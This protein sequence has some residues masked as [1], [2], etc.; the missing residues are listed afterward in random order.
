MKKRN[1][2]MLAGVAAFALG[3]M[4]SGAWAA[5]D[6][7]KG[8]VRIGMSSFFDDI[9]DPHGH[10][11]GTTMPFLWS[12][13]DG[14]VGV[15]SGGDF[16][17]GLAVS[18]KITEDG[19]GWVFTLRK[20]V[21]FHDG[22][23]M[24]PEDVRFGWERHVRPENK[25]YPATELARIVEKVEIVDDGTV[26]FRTKAP[27]PILRDRLVSSANPVSSKYVKKVGHEAFGQRPAACAGPFRFVDHKTAEWIKFEAFSDYWDTEN[28]A[29]VK[30]VLVRNI[31]EA[32]TRVA[33]LKAGEV[34][35][36][37]G[38]WSAYIHEIK[39]AS[40]LRVISTPLANASEWAVNL[41]KPNPLTDL[42]VRQA[43]SCAIDRKAMIDKVFFGEGE[44][45]GHYFAPY[46]LGHDPGFWSPDPYDPEKAKRLL[47]EAGYP[48][49]F[50]LDIYMA[51]GSRA[52][53]SVE[54]GASFLQKV[55]IR[56]NIVA[57]EQG[58]YY[59]KFRDKSLVG[60]MP[61]AMAFTKDGGQ[62]AETFY[63]TNGG[64]SFYSNPEMDD[65]IAKQKVEMN[66]GKRE[67][68]LKRIGWIIHD[69]LVRIPIVALNICYGAGP[70]IGDWKPNV[71]TVYFSKWETIRLKE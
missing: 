32:S 6:A 54:P 35:L 2:L 53:L 30:E 64:Y 70:R 63:M 68:Y 13:S 60:L 61:I 48:D 43:V 3:S 66:P 18:W 26:V 9:V 11:G 55:G 8:Q 31:P 42:R 34:D 29:S 19:L 7:P 5:A 41:L 33:A 10:K 21:R 44:P 62:L 20:G 51:E 38:V 14:L 4:A 12:I 46:T 57:M 27:D 25:A 16:R 47:K 71:A 24:T 28:R 15:T 36:I 58:Q 59:G 22:E 40:N 39:A 52:A 49:G 65:L 50:E 45:L 37:E 17:P 23:V 1:I 56:C 69:Q 67:E